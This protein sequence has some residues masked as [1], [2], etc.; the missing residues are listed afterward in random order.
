MRVNAVVLLKVRRE[1][2]NGVAEELLEIDGV[3]EV[4]TVAGQHDLVAI[5]RAETDD[6]FAAIVTEGMLEVEGIV[7]SET[8]I[9]LKMYS[10]HDPGS[11]FSPGVCSA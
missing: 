9:A 4:Y 1:A 7:A 11:F 2:I 10:K 5:L 8:L 3:S 6:L